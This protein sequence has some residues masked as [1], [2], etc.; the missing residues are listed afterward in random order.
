MATNEW[1]DRW[2]KRFGIVYK[3]SHGEKLDADIPAAKE[4]LS[5]ALVD[6]FNRY[7]EQDIFNADE[8]GL[9]WRAMPNGYHVFKANELSGSKISKERLTILLCTSMNG[10]K[11]PVL[12]IGKSKIPRC[13]QGVKQLPVN[14]ENNK[15]T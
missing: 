12:V 11:Q 9:L 1:L 13:F 6:V 14:Y 15:N 2:K 10:E 7:Q 4:W 5:T 8:T 3:K